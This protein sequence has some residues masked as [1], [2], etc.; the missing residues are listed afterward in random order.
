MTGKVKDRGQITWPAE[1]EH[2]D[3]HEQLTE[4]ALKTKAALGVG[5]STRCYLTVKFVESK[6]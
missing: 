3:L 6:T 2:H 5:P 1:P 4:L